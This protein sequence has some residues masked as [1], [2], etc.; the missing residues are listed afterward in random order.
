L[1][2]LSNFYNR[3]GN[4]EKTMEYLQAAADL[5]PADAKAHQRVA[6]FYWEKAFRDHR[7]SKEQKQV[8][9]EAGIAAVDRAI[10]LDGEYAEALTYKNILLRMQANELEDGDEK[11]RLIA[12]A[13]ALRDRVMELKKLQSGRLPPPDGP[14]AVRSV[15]SGVAPTKTHDVK[16]VYPEE[17]RAAGVKGAVIVEATIGVTGEVTAAR[18]LRSVPMLDGAA[19]EAVR[20][21]RYTV[22]YYNGQAVPLI[23]TVVVNFP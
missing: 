14:A 6:T 10:A 1:N 2:A 20:Q 13:D 18:V 16:P 17:A 4:F 11:Q 9:V 23:L 12:E 22:T 5:D 15:R 8:Y 3:Q 21:W 7:L 19:L